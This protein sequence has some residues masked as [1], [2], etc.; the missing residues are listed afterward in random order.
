M[1]KFSVYEAGTTSPRA[2]LQAYLE[3]EEAL[4]RLRVGVRG[5]SREVVQR[6]ASL[7][8]KEPDV[9]ICGLHELYYNDL[10]VLFSCRD[11]VW[12]EQHGCVPIKL[13]GGTWKFEFHILFTVFRG[14]RPEA[15]QRN[16]TNRRWSE[17][18]RGNRRDVAAE[19]SSPGRLAPGTTKGFK[20]H[21]ARSA[22][23]NLRSGF[24]LGRHW[25]RFKPWLK[26]L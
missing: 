5:W 12:A 2:S 3:E 16:R 14:Q 7:F 26:V 22:G 1:A 17:T 23:K 19:A 13:D 9:N 21:G 15:R 20:R 4:V 6:A 11:S 25:A 24:I 8:C 18:A 10:T